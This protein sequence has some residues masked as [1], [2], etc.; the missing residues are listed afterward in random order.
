VSPLVPGEHANTMAMAPTQQHF[1]WDSAKAISNFQ[2][3]GIRFR[4]A[5]KAIEDPLAVTR[6]DID[7]GWT[8][9]RWTTLG[10]AEGTLL[11]VVH[12]LEDLEDQTIRVRIISARH[13]TPDERRQYESGNYRIEEAVMIN[14]SNPDQWIRGRFYREGAVSILPVHVAQDLVVRLNMFAK[15]RGVDPSD[16]ANALLTDAI[17]QPPFVMGSGES[18]G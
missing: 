14:K 15:Q 5:S 8:E 9:E 3:Q 2:K 13:P 12:T 17:S 4:D 6:H 1:D 18:S 16:L 7:H 10:E 11:H